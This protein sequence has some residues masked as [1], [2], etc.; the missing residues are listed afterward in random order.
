MNSIQ[1]LKIVLP[2][3]HCESHVDSYDHPDFWRM[4]LDFVSTCKNL[5]DFS[6]GG[7][8]VPDEVRKKL[9]SSCSSR[10][11]LARYIS[12][13]RKWGHHPWLEKKSFCGPFYN[14]DQ[15][16]DDPNK[17]HDI[18]HD[19]YDEYY[20]AVVNENQ[21]M[22]YDSDDSRDDVNGSQQLRQDGLERTQQEAKTIPTKTNPNMRRSNHKPTQ[23][24]KHIARSHSKIG[25]GKC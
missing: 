6:F 10:F 24:P 21:S 17:R 14:S 2:L 19:D 5:Q 18:L 4:L 15:H 20:L 13:L 11:V 12:V 22:E 23:R 1:S 8:R 9:R 25:W 3:F 7:D 16:T